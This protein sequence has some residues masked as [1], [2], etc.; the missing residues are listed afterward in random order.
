MKR[1]DIEDISH[2]NMVVKEKKKKNEELGYMR[3]E[4]L[5]KMARPRKTTRAL[6]RRYPR[7]DILGDVDGSPKTKKYLRR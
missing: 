2:T 6:R 7:G 1:D 3:D 5:P 4:R